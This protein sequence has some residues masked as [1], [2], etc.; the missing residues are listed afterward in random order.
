MSLYRASNMAHLQGSIDVVVYML[1][2]W[3]ELV[4]VHAIIYRCV[5]VKLPTT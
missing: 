4:A 3:F 5:I 2:D 1:Y